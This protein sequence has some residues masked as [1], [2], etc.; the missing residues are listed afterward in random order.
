ML[1]EAAH[2]R[3]HK[4]INNSKEDTSSK[5]LSMRENLGQSNGIR[6]C[7]GKETTTG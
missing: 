7:T 5:H 4:I 6:T 2:R 1:N 3:P